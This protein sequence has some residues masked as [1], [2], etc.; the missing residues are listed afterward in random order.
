MSGGMGCERKFT[1]KQSSGEATSYY[2]RSA[3]ARA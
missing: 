3:V 2:R 1:I